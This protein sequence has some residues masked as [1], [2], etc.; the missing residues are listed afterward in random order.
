MVPN[1]KRYSRVPMTRISRIGSVTRIPQSPRQAAHPQGRIVSLSSLR[2]RRLC[3]TRM[4]PNGVVLR[5]RYRMIRRSRR[6]KMGSFLNRTAHSSSLVCVRCMGWP[7]QPTV[8][9]SSLKAPSFLIIG[10]RTRGFDACEQG[11]ASVQR[12]R[13]RRSPGQGKEGKEREDKKESFCFKTVRSR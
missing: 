11:W 5:L 12:R 3:R 10:N 4:P 6:L 8:C 1:W 7:S 13:P 2:R 9:L